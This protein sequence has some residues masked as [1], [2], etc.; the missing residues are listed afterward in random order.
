M[1]RS[2]AKA[3]GASSRLAD[4][5]RRTSF[6]TKHMRVGHGSSLQTTPNNNIHV[7]HMMDIDGVLHSVIEYVIYALIRNMWL[8]YKSRS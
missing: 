7:P 6:T 8:K 2:H 5:Y 3:V 1:H 4:K